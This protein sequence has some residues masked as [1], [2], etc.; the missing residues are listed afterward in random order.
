MDANKLIFLFSIIFISLLLFAIIFKHKTLRK[1][2]SWTPSK[3]LKEKRQFINGINMYWLEG[4]QGPN[5]ILI[6]GIGAS[7]YCWRLFTPFL[8]K[9]FRVYSL[10]LPGFGM[11][12][13]LHT[14]WSLDQISQV[15]L[16]FTK[17]LKLKHYILCGS[18][19]GS[20][21]ALR[22]A[23]LAPRD[24]A[25]VIAM[26][27]ATHPKLSPPLAWMGQLHPTLKP[28]FGKW[29][30]RQALRKV[31]SALTPITDVD[32]EQYQKPYALN[33]KKIS[34]FFYATKVL[35]DPRLPQLFSSLEVPTLILYGQQDQMV[36]QKVIDLLKQTLPQS[37]L[38]IH[39]S[40]GHHLQED[41]PQWCFEQTHQF[42][43]QIVDVNK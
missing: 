34:S 6:H 3:E 14:D 11:S 42:L 36:P 4:G 15:L 13:P 12:D 27:P 35:R 32:I 9:Y 21:I 25:A 39:P 33:S 8:T 31:R 37:Q 5:F 30:I 38:R 10:D 17:T 22:M 7:N 23:Q 40:A 20:A 18:S 2:L 29:V 26:A 16:D 24:C 41:E 28:F 1:Y 19:M 43:S